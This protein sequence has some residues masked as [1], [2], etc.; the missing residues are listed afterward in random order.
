LRNFPGYEKFP[1]GAKVADQ[2]KLSDA[3]NVPDNQ[4]FAV[5][6]PPFRERLAGLSSSKS[7]LLQTG[8]QQKLLFLMGFG[9]FRYD[10][11]SPKFIAEGSLRKFRRS[12][13]GCLPEQR[14]SMESSQYYFLS[15]HFEFDGPSVRSSS[16]DVTIAG[17]LVGATVCRNVVALSSNRHC[18]RLLP[19]QNP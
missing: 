2:S 16:A 6:P 15:I 10:R 3:A 17:C 18:L 19:G 9:D 1:N 12:D 13:C 7:S 11:C 4:A 5:Q 14:A 8:H